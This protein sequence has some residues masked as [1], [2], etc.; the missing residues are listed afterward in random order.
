MGVGLANTF[1]IL[2]STVWEFF[3]ICFFLRARRLD[4]QVLVLQQ[5]YSKYGNFMKQKTTNFII[6]FKDH[7]SFM[8]QPPSLKTRRYC[9]VW[10]ITAAHYEAHGAR[11]AFT[12]FTPFRRSGRVTH[13]TGQWLDSALEKSKKSQRNPKTIAKKSKIPK[14]SPKIRTL[15]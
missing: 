9:L 15:F 1:E 2:D 8:K 7:L 13:T 10:C 12:S 4:N 6:W 14:V 11:L 5:V 3:L